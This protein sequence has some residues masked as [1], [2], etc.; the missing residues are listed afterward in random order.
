MWW[1]G[2][3]F[4]WGSKEG[5]E[6][7]VVVF[8]WLSSQERHL[9]PYVQLYSTFGWRSLIC[10]ADFLT[11][12]F[13]EK[14]SSLA[15]GVLKE[16]LQE[17]KIRPSPIVF[18][19]FSGGP[20]GCMYKVLQLINGRCKGLLDLDEYQLVKDCLCGQIYDSS[21]VDFTS[22][23][24]TRFLLHPSVLKRPHPPR[25]VS[26]MAKALASGLDTLF[27]SRFEAERADYWQ[28]LYSSVNVGPF[29]IFCSEDDELAPYQVICN[30]AQ[31]LQELGGDVKLIKWNSSPHVGH[32]K[33]HASDYRA[34][35]FELV[36]KAAM[37]YAQRRL[38][39]QGLE[40]PSISESVCNLHKAAASSSESLRRVATDPSDHFFLPSS[41]ECEDKKDTNL[42]KGELFHTQ[43]MPSINAHGVLGQILFD[44]CVPKNIEG[45]DIKPSTSL[46]GRQTFAVARRHG[47][48]YP[49]KCIRRSRL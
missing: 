38:Q 49:M 15:D 2:G 22:D 39:S 34:G 9:K 29:L 28:T 6:G 26:W 1:E 31:H 33:F 37:I 25:V 3:R 48:F 32:Y 21:P 42:Q 30:F 41:M 10:H 35:V 8:A 40:G 18:A 47:L 20:K 7:I 13:P 44:I 24:G 27:I 16:L 19:A 23:L 11:L 5:R 43:N 12:F 46:N 45:W 36:G 17:L 4:Y 14:A